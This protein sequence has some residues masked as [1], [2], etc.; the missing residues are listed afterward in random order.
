MGFLT[1]PPSSALG[2][3]W[4]EGFVDNFA[5]TTSR[6][7]IFLLFGFG[8]GGYFLEGVGGS[9]IRIDLVIEFVFSEKC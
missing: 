3:I 6:K 4:R 7:A 8:A 1:A 9:G 5:T 2:G